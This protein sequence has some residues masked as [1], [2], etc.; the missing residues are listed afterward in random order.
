[1]EIDQFSKSFISLRKVSMKWLN[2]V[3]LA[4]SAFETSNECVESNLDR[5]WWFEDK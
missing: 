5:Q 3:I 1:M 2:E 4:E